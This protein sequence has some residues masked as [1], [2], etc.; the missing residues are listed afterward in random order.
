VTVKAIGCKWVYSIKLRSDGTLDRYKAWLVALA[1]SQGWPLHQMDVKNAFLHGDLKEEVYMTLP[2]SVISNSSLDV[3]KL[4]FIWTEIGSLSLVWQIS[5]HLASVFFSAKQVWLFLVS[6]QDIYGFCSSP[7][8]CWWYCYYWDKFHL[9]YPS[10]AAS[11]GL[12]SY[13][14]SWFAYILL[15]VGAS[16]WYILEST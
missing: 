6:L 13:D 14:E 11:S 4:L 2:P 9:D 1:T 3:W 5:S 16:H 8:L 10:L 7:Y 15:G 12:I